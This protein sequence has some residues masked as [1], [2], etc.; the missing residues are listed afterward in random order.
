MT[1]IP[2]DE[3]GIEAALMEA[4]ERGWI[5]VKRR[6]PQYQ[7][8]VRHSLG[9]V[10]SAYLEAVGAEVEHR[11]AWVGGVSKSSSPRSPIALPEGEAI[12][13]DANPHGDWR[14]ESRLI[15]NWKPLTDTEER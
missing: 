3:D 2:V 14:I 1:G 13:Q 4:E 12:A 8:A 10:I 5:K 7:R 6:R 11:S 15:T 9:A